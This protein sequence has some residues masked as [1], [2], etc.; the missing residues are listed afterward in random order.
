VTWAGAPDAPPSTRI[1][2]LLPSLPATERRVGEAVVA[3]R[4]GTVERT[5]QEL[6]EAVGVGRASVVRAAQAFGYD[7]Y[8]Q[9]RVALAR[10]IALEQSS[11][12]PADAGTSLTGAVHA[13]TRRFAARL[14]HSM[15]ALTEEALVDVVATLDRA[16]RVLVVANGLSAPLGLDLQLRLTAAGRPAELLGDALAQQIAARQL[17][18]AS[19]CVVL[20]GSGV[21]RA[22]LDTV[23]AARAGGARVLALT[24]FARSPVAEG[25]DVTL[26]VPPIT[27]G[28]HDELVHTSRAALVLLVE[29]VVELLV[30]HR[31]ERG[32][33]ARAAALSVLGD[34]LQD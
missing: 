13:A 29:Q 24:S 21:N 26:V 34:G 33:A 22:T 1:V 2:A 16:E 30:A 20:S 18:A 6:A 3:D 10:E 27:D 14:A 15:A 17:G 23:R 4:A 19:A 28:F 12:P 8:P 7:G 31:G 9:L 11:A 25:A 5:A 32:R